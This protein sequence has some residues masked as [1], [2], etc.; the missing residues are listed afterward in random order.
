MQFSNRPNVVVTRAEVPVPETRTEPNKESLSTRLNEAQ[1]EVHAQPV[2]DTRYHL[3]LV[4]DHLKPHLTFKFT[5]FEVLVLL[6]EIC[7]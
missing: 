1:Q 4:I 5:H 3:A 6:V 7:C 2:P